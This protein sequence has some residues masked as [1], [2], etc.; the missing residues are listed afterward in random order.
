VIS[1]VIC[2]YNRAE[3]LRETLDGL[4]RM[5]VPPEVKWELIVVDNNSTDNTR[6]VVEEFVQTSG[7]S[8]DYLF[9]PRQG[10]SHALNLAI[11]KSKGDIVAFLDDDVI[12][13]EDWLANVWK[14]FSTDGE[15]GVLSGRVELA[16]PLDLPLMIITYPK[17]KLAMSYLDVDGLIGAGCCSTFRRSVLDDVGDFDTV[18][19]P[20]SRFRAT[21]DR[22]YGYR[23]WKVGTKMLY[24]PTVLV[25]H[26]HGR[27]TRKDEDALLHDY[28]I[29]TGAYYAKH[30][31]SGDAFT[32]R[33]MYWT[34]A[35]RAR[36]VLRGRN[37]QWG[38]RTTLR[39]FVGFIGYVAYRCWTRVW[40]RRPPV[41]RSRANSCLRGE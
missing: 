22:D 1:A 14:E 9:E 23:A 7:L 18:L 25:F 19:G 39:L 35:S 5:S 33:L 21:E 40:T 11:K 34:I 24:A 10:K 15:L 29:G 17:R 36:Q 37:I 38:F 12:P 16:N 30:I 8:V 2:T 4:G 28:N 31:L 32:A 26:N 13:A 3:R 6:S 27:Q 41:L 20:G